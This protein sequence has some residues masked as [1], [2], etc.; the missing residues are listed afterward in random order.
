[1]AGGPRLYWHRRDALSNDDFEFIDIIFSGSP[2]EVALHTYNSPMVE[3]TVLSQH[4]FI[5]SY[6]GSGK[7]FHWKRMA[8]AHP[9][10]NG[11]G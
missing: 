9:E 11:A 4:E 1:M 6:I 2:I 7:T 5:Y 8:L 3:L 10:T